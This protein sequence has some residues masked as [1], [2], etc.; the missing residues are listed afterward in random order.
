MYL[1]QVF[2]VTE[3]EIYL[4]VVEPLCEGYFDGVLKTLKV[5]IRQ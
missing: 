3:I 5:Q 1:M 2:H 4:T